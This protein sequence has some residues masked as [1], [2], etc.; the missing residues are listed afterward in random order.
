[1]CKEEVVTCFKVPF[2]HLLRKYRSVIYLKTYYHKIP[3]EE[4]TFMKKSSISAEKIQKIWP[5]MLAVLRTNKL[6]HVLMLRFM[7]S[8]EL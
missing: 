7:S 1:M 2:Q 6:W 4:H 5:A 3:N 8:S